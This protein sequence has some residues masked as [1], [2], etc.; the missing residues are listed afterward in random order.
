MPF[1]L[2]LLV[3]TA[4]VMFIL[5]ISRIFLST[6]GNVDVL[7]GTGILLTI[8]IG[9]SILSASPQMRSSSLALVAGGF[10]IVI[11]LGGWL[12][13]G[14]AEEKGGATATLPAEGTRVGGARVLVEQRAE[15]RSLEG[16]REDRHRQ[17]HAQRPER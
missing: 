15:V 8:L 13:I 12:L 2:P 7:V 4:V 11:M 14:N 5:N 16:R 3:V 9:A 17:D 1:V 10:V 6:H